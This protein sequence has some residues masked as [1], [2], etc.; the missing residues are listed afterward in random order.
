[1][2]KPTTALNQKGLIGAR[3][4]KSMLYGAL[5]CSALIST[6]SQAELGPS[7]LLVHGAHFTAESWRAVETSLDNKVK[8]MTV[9]LP[10]RHGKFIAKHITLEL[11]AAALCTELSKIDGDKIVA[12]HSQGGAVVN[13]ALALCP[14]N[15]LKK[16]IYI[17]SVSPFN[18]ETAFELL[19]KQ[20]DKHYFSGINYNKAAGSL[21]ISNLD[22]FTQAFAPNATSLEKDWLKQ[23]AVNEPSR[24]GSDSM[25]LDKEQFSKLK[26]YYIFAKNDKVISLKSQQKI[27]A[28]MDI[29]NS[30][31]LDSGHLPML[32]HSKELANIL[33]EIVQD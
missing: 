24:L 26:K 13:A 14:D 2:K 31:T 7:L 19:S 20:D 10:G 15:D 28:R 27:A 25:K 4:K 22:N 11:S 21:E 6:N 12:A 23:H 17:T 29:T 30:F 32:T 8:T 3:L 18:G 5:L 9:N 16:I 33:S 1:M